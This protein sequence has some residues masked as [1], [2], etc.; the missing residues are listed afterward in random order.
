[1]GTLLSQVVPL[2]LGAAISPVLFLLTLTTLTGERPLAR[3]LALTAGAAVP[4]ALLGAFAFAISGSLHTSS[5]TKAGIDL[6]LGV[7]LLLVG[8][9]ALVEAPPAPRPADEPKRAAG[10]ARS[11]ALGFGAMATNVTT[12]ALY[13]PAMKLIATSHVSDADRALAHVIVALITLALAVLPVTLVAVA[14]VSSR[15]ILGALGAFMTE[16]GA[17]SPSPWASDSAPG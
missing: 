6:A 3:G 15:R 8:V 17:R 11:F 4:L 9:H 1:M 5:T 10:P 7:V 13:L 2:A 12:L 16:H 14:P